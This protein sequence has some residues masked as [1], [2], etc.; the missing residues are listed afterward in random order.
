MTEKEAAEIRKMDAEI[1]KLMAETRKL[2]A[3]TKLSEQSSRKIL[4]E[5]YFYPFVAISA[6]LAGAVGVI[7]LFA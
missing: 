6:L 3:D 2:L 5:A 4:I 7:K 1:M